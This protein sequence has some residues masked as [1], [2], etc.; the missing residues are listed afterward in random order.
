M[1]Q[2]FL[3][4]L[5]H[6]KNYSLHTIEAYRKDLEDIDSFLN[7]RCSASF[8][9]TTHHSI[10]SWIVESLERGLAASSVRRKISALKSYY[11]WYKR[12]HNQFIDPTSKIV[13]PKMPKRLPSFAEENALSQQKL[14]A[15][16]DDSFQG[17]RDQTIVELLYQTGIRSSELI[18]LKHLNISIEKR[19]IKVLG[20]RNKE[21]L[22]PVNVLM[23]NQLRNYFNLR[24]DLNDI[25]DDEFFFLTKKGKKLY[26]KLVYRIVNDYLSRVS[27]LNKKSPH[28]LRHTFATHLLNKGADI[29]AIKELLGHSSLASTQVYTHNSVEQLLKVYNASHPK[30]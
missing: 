2:N 6:E 29:N 7:Q 24:H 13:W 4:Y 14:N 26:P 9:S 11:K 27:S 22:I 3:D 28:V 12:S 19:E 8:Q 1:I 21:R 23:A 20:K 30:S 5:E 10:R 16:F 17:I 25:Q 15:L 18:G